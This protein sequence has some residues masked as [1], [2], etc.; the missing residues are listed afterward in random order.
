MF[1]PSWG[2]QM[3]TLISMTICSFS[4]YKASGLASETK[5]L[6]ILSDD[7]AYLDL[8]AFD[9]FLDGRAIN[10]STIAAIPD[11]VVI[12]LMDERFGKGCWFNHR[13]SV[14][15]GCPALAAMFSDIE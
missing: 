12:S 1:S 7:Y 8:P 4:N 9:D 6:D 2:F 3:L 13:L 10:L 5:N 14:P 11:D 15:S